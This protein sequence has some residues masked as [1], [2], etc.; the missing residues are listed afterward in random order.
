MKVIDYDSDVLD[1]SSWVKTEYGLYYAKEKI[2][3]IKLSQR[4]SL[5]DI[6]KIIDAFLADGK[7][8]IICS[9]LK[10]SDLAILREKRI[11]YL[12]NDREIKIFGREERQIFKSSLNNI[13]LG[14][15]APTLLVSPTGL[16]IID[17]ILK[18]PSEELKNDTP[19]KL[20]K[21]FGLS[22]PKLSNIMN[23]FRV[24]KLTE[25]KRELLNIEISW[26]VEV[27]NTPIT[28]RKMTPFQTKKTRRYA[29]KEQLDDFKFKDLI[30]KLKN[31]NIDVEFGGL[32]YL[33]NLGSIRTE[34]FDV[35]VRADQI[36]DI[37]EKMELRPAKKNELTK[38]IFITP[39]DGDLREERFYSKIKNYHNRFSGLENL[40]PL[41]FLWG[42]NY[43]ESRVQEERKSLLENYFNEIKKN[44]H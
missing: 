1:K 20:C 42:I 34:E 22:R 39:I 10:E 33:K 16:E 41:R 21:D 31:E 29:F 26:W 11:S 37:V 30:Q 32:S 35:V 13:F 17:T 24:K 28:K 27:F 12:I 2:K 36:I 9:S 8:G 5:K 23:A 14:D 7:V 38:N 44:N 3:F 43:E 18:L 4:E 40:N 25:L 6:V 19:T 15:V